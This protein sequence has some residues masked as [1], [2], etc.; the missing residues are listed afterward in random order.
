MET[1]RK[2]DESPFIL[3]GGVAMKK[4]SIF[5]ATVALMTSVVAGAGSAS[6]AHF[7]EIEKQIYMLTQQL[8]RLQPGVPLSDIQI[9]QIREQA[10]KLTSKNE[11]SMPSDGIQSAGSSQSSPAELTDKTAVTALG[12]DLKNEQSDITSSSPAAN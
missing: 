10:R 12:T 7:S 4:L 11:Y 2:M 6:G 1:L 5:I 3:N 9:Y 8:K